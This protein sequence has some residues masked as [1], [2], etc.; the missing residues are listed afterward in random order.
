MAT[1]DRLAPPPSTP[2][3]ASAWT[4]RRAIAVTLAAVAAIALLQV[5]QSSSVASTGAGMQ[6]LEREK[7]AQM[8]QIHQLEKGIDSHQDAGIRMSH[9][10]EGN[11]GSLQCSD[12]TEPIRHIAKGTHS[13]LGIPGESERLILRG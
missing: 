6:R 13:Q 7:A 9:D 10:G 4:P 11:M 5:L 1:L 2:A 12:S 3:A 8:A